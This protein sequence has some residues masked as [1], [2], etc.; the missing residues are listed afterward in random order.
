MNSKKLWDS[1]K[2]ATNMKPTKKSQHVVDGLA[3]ANEL[4]VFYKL[5]DNSDFSSECSVVLDGI[6]TDDAERLY[7]DPKCVNNVF[8]QVNV[9]KATGPDGISAFLLKTCADELITAWA[10]I[11]Q[12]S[13]DS[14]T[15]PAQWKS[16][17]ITPVP[18]KP[19]PQENND[20]RT[21]ALTSVVMKCL[22]KLTVSKVHED[23]GP[24]L[25]PYQFA[26]THQRG[27]DDAI[28]SIV[29]LVTKHLEN[30]KAYARLLL[31]HPSL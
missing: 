10:P 18:K 25:D 15:V 24:Q 13:L 30:P 3:K 31:V 26:Y 19:C 2:T 9:N 4:D 12:R 8:K 20:F 28:N 21:V 14:H 23:V 16:A 6:N 7:I 22:E 1:L 11:F 17:I 29:H 5:F 27:T